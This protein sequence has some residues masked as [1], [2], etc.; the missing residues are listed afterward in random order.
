MGKVKAKTV[1]TGASVGKFIRS[2][3]DP[4]R[5]ADAEALVAVFTETVREPAVMWGPSIIGFG[6][7][8]YKYASGREGDTPLAAFSPRKRQLVLYLNEYFDT[9]YDDVLMRLGPHT[10]GKGCLYIQRLELVDTRV[11]RELIARTVAATKAREAKA[12][13]M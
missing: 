11:L 10:L 7:Y 9:G 12:N 6:N 3:P 4:V 5:R 1:P 2:V 13:A 8:H